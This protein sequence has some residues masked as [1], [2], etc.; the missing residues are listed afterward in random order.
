MK[1]NNLLK[2]LLIGCIFGFYLQ[3]DTA[4][5]ANNGL[6]LSPA[7]KQWLMEH[8][9]VRVS[10]DSHYEPIEFIQNG[11]HS[12]ITGD[13]FALFSEL[14]GI[15]FQLLEHD[16]WSDTMKA[17]EK[18]EIDIFTSLQST[19]ERHNKMT[20]NNLVGKKLAVVDG[21]FW[22]DLVKNDFPNIELVLVNDIT[23]GLKLTALGTTD[24]FLGSFAALSYYLNKQEISNLMVAGNAPYEINYG[25]AVRKDWPELVSILNKAINV[26]T[27]EQ[28]KTIRNKW[29]KLDYEPPLLSRRVTAVLLALSILAGLS[30]LIAAYISNTLRRKVR[31]KTLELYQVNQQLE[32]MVE[33]RTQDLRR[34]NDK[35]LSSKRQLT[36]TNRI[37]EV[38]VNRDNLTKIPNRKR[39]EEVLKLA[40]QEAI[41]NQEPLSII[42]ADIDHF[43]KL[44]D[45]YGHLIGDDCLVEVAGCL[46]SFT[47]RGGEFV[48]RFGGEEFII[49][50]PNLTEEEAKIYANLLLKKVHA[51][52]IEN[53]DAPKEKFV[54]LSMGVASLDFSDRNM[55]VEKLIARSDKAMYQAKNNGRNQVAVYSEIVGKKA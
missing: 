50:L 16:K 51:L 20:M 14:L 12:G 18:G 1:I 24:A 43:K 34:A 7:E 25:T 5:E 55:T 9:I 11:Q 39:L 3:A 29:I 30:A 49:V 21:Y 6:N 2:L 17:M 41:E 22:G 15:E 19:S 52:G 42:L 8:P 36:S 40:F 38:E 23:E 26:I 31:E 27:P 28:H 35:L 44:N 32:Q 53:I 47:K 33:S 45:H 13:Y 10:P 4:Q 48:A 54:T 37:L 46:N